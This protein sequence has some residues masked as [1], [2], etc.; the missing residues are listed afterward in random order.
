[1]QQSLPD[2]SLATVERAGHAVMADNP[3]GTERAVQAFL[4]RIGRPQQSGPA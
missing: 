1:M 4:A 3:E 2:A